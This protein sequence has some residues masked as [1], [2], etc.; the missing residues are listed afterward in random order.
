MSG[1]NVSAAILDANL[2][3]SAHLNATGKRELSAL[4]EEYY[5][6]EQD[7]ASFF[8]T[9]TGIEDDAELKKH[10]M[11]VQTDAYS[12]FP[13]NCIRRFAFTKLKISRFPAYQDLLRLGRERP[14]ALFLDLGCCFGN[15][16]RK[17]VVD[18]FPVQ[19]AIASDLRPEFWDLG[20]QLFKDDKEKF[21]AVFLPGDIFDNN[22]VPD[23]RSKVETTTKL[24]PLT[25]LTSLAPLLGRLSAIHTSAF[26]HLFDEEQQALVARKVASLLSAEPGSVIFGAHGGRAE[27]GL[28]TEIPSNPVRG[29]PMFCH[30]PES[31]VHLWEKEVFQEG[32]VR[33][34]ATL[35]EVPR[36]EIAHI[37]KA[38]WYLLVWSVTRL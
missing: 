26:F 30:S 17:A 23:D 29:T 35:Q 19:Q 6:L 9:Y 25:E 31:W 8:K 27:K 13:Y 38:K 37:P 18:G 16:V 20:Y 33:V 7:E 2:K 32:Q 11:K 22:F 21:P 10:I 36:P 1:D 4:D 28:R 15:D 3:D 34:W 24:P 14:G 12:V 5:S